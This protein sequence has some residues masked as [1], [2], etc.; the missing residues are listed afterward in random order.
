MQKRPYP[1]TA[2]RVA[3]SPI[4]TVARARE[5]LKKYKDGEKIGFTLTS[6]LKSM[7]LIPRSNGMYQLG[8]KYK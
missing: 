8:D 7:G 4:K 3:K 1:I 2:E 6:S 5:V